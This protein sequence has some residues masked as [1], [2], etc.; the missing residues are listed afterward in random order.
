[1]VALPLDLLREFAG[2]P[3]ATI[4]HSEYIKRARGLG[5][6]AKQIKVWCLLVWIPRESWFSVKQCQPPSPTKNATSLPGACACA[7][8]RS[9]YGACLSGYRV[10]PGFLLNSVSPHHPLRLQQACQGPVHAR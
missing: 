1:M 8:S 4:M 2:R 10:S 3:R 7:P 5:M 9:R 6:R